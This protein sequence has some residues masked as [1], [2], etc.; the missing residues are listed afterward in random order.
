MSSSVLQAAQNENYLNAFV[1]SIVTAISITIGNYWS[2]ALLRLISQYTV[3][4]NSAPWL[5]GSALVVAALG[6]M[7]I[8]FV[9][10]ISSRF[11][12]KSE[13]KRKGSKSK[14]LVN[15]ARK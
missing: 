3:E 6:V 12:K 11:M 1:L 13:A 8:I 15:P 10:R 7:A 5:I 14:A 9:L 4:G 2:N